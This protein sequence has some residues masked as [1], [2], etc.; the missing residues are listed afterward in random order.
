LNATSELSCEVQVLESI[1]SYECDQQQEIRN[2]WA[3]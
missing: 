1:Y 3:S 2:Q